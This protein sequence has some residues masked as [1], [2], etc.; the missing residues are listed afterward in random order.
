VLP[1]GLRSVLAH[2]RPVFQTRYLLLGSL[3]D[4]PGTAFRPGEVLVS[5]GLVTG[6]I[7]VVGQLLV[8]GG[9]ALGARRRA[10][11]EVLVGAG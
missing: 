8:A 4:D 11:R 2:C 5:Y 9:H 3:G 6:G 10:R 1:S 7:F